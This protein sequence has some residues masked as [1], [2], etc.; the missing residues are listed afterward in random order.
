MIKIS[1]IDFWHERQGDNITFDDI[2]D[3][4]KWETK[5]CSREYIML[6][7]GI[8]IF[9]IDKIKQDFPNYNFI[10]T[11]AEEADILICS[12]FGNIKM[13]YPNKIK[14]FLGF[15]SVCKDYVERA[16]DT[17]YCFSSFSDILTNHNYN[18][19]LYFIYHGFPLYKKLKEPR[20]MYPKTKFCICIISNEN[21]S[22]RKEFVMELMKYK[23]VDCYG[24]L[25]K[26]TYN[27]I[28]D[29]TSWYNPHIMDI[30]K[31]YKFM[32]CMEN[33]QVT[34]YWTEKIINGYIGNTIPIYWG[35]PNICDIFNTKSFIDI[36][37][38]GIE[39]GIQIIKTIDNNHMIYEDMFKS[40]LVTENLY[41]EQYDMNYY[42]KYMNNIFSKV[43]TKKEE[44]TQTICNIFKIRLVINL[45]RRKDRYDEFCRRCPF[46]SNIIMRFNATDGQT[47]NNKNYSMS[48]GAIGC[49]MSHYMTWE[50]IANSNMN[51]NDMAIVFEDDNMFSDR[52]EKEIHNINKLKTDKP[53][54]CY[55]GG[56]FKEN[57][58][59]PDLN[60]FPNIYTKLENNL[61]LRPQNKYL[62][63]Q[64]NNWI[65]NSNEII[66]IDMIT[67]WERCCS[68]IIMNKMAA[69]LLVKY[70]NKIPDIAVDNFLFK[71]NSFTNL[72]NFY[73]YFPHLC[74]S[75]LNY[76]SDIQL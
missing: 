9:H 20:I 71:V 30:I 64:K 38:L 5:I 14:I 52:F 4:T 48:K 67:N 11:N 47:I 23:H 56:R 76:K 2:N 53:I 31:D 6:D 7:S 25:F 27:D 44:L 24:K 57:F 17:N 1:Y 70:I 22:F 15:E 29:T 74:Y 61:Y 41:D 32:I 60:Q 75:P 36:N 35:D 39:N 73:D 19:G 16:D 10:I 37:T 43:I 46:N 45:E 51:D 63:T 12:C 58:I 65:F 40:P 34:N 18:F 28:I 13:K 55:I 3:I 21:A 62:V 54:I 42:N 59:P 72:I 66:P 69:K 26:N 8:G 49:F 50:M 68:C 33:T